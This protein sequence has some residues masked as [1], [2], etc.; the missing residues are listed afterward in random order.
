MLP[1]KP[2]VG[3]KPK[4]SANP[5]SKPTVPHRTFDEVLATLQ[6]P[7]L[8]KHESEKI[9][10]DFPPPEN[11]PY[12][13]RRWN[14]GLDV[15]LRRKDFDV[16]RLSYLHAICRAY[17]DIAVMEQ[18]VRE[19]GFTIQMGVAVKAN[20]LMNHIARLS[21]QIFSLSR[22]IGLVVTPRNDVKGLKGSKVSDSIQ[23][24][25]DDGAFE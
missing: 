17:L 9:H 25:E 2:R 13:V 12:Y 15:L 16:Y 22:A 19:Q 1:A 11:H 4:K 3:S 24:E 10:P 6:V 21:K 23:V 5:T 20:P 8:H 14:A 7:K 18:M